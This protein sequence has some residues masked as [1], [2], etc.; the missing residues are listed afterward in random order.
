MFVCLFEFKSNNKK[1]ESNIL[2]KKKQTDGFGL[3]YK[4][5]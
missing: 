3:I 1:T 2:L 5:S 4:G